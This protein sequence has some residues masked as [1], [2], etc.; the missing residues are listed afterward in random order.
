MW[1]GEDTKLDDM[2]KNLGKSK[3]DGDMMIRMRM[4]MAG[5]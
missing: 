5:K 4:M 1:C 3:G 2:V